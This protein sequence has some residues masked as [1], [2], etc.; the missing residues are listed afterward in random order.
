MANNRHSFAGDNRE[1]PANLPDVTDADDKTS[2]AGREH[3]LDAAGLSERQRACVMHAGEGLSSKE[4]G[5]LLGIAPSTVDNHIH[6]A[7]GKLNARNRWHAAQLMHPK[8]ME[9]A[10]PQA[11]APNSLVPPVGGRPNIASSRQRLAHIATIAVASLISLSAA[12]VFI[13]GAIHIFDL[14]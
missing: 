4:I 10:P 14:R 11:P 1:T 3:I 2:A 9:A 13:L 6:A 8:R 5:R 12:C 7:I